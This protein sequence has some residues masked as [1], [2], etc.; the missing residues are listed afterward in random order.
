MRCFFSDLFTGCLQ[1]S[2]YSIYLWISVW[3]EI[4]D[5]YLKQR[6]GIKFEQ[7]SALLPSYFFLIYL[8]IH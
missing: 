5:A 6:A 7:I 8:W 2:K 1:N 3:P 4:A